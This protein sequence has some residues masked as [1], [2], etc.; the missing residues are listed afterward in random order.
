MVFIG[1]GGYG[2][3]CEKR[4]ITRRDGGS[5]SDG[6]GCKEGLLEHAAPLLLLYARPLLVNRGSPTLR[7]LPPFSCTAPITPPA[8][9]VMVCLLKRRRAA[10]GACSRS[11]MLRYPQPQ[12]LCPRH[13]K[14]VPNIPPQAARGVP[15]FR[16]LTSP[17]CPRLGSCP[18]SLTYRAFRLESY[19]PPTH[20][21][22]ACAWRAWLHQPNDT[23]SSW[24]HQQ[25]RRDDRRSHYAP[26]LPSSPA[27]SIHRAELPAHPRRRLPRRCQPQPH[28]LAVQ[29]QP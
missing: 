23:L 26:P 25:H 28:R 14:T 4:A 5:D 9:D 12:P 3:G 20:G 7:R 11:H 2:Y 15:P 22:H 19:V 21:P 10:R 24:Q 8:G 1:S 27:S 17:T 6:G 29:L 16:Y 18:S 13:D